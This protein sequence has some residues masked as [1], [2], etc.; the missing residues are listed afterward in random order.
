M[1]ATYWSDMAYTRTCVYRLYDA[2]GALLYVGL[3]KNPLGRFS[4]HGAKPWWRE[5]AYKELV[6]FDNRTDAQVAERQ[7]IF[8]E[9]PVHNVTRPKECC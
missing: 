1:P 9:E 6:W 7:A 8:H 2:E 4:K 5:V 3:T